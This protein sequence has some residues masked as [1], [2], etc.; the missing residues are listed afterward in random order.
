MTNTSLPS[1]HPVSQHRNRL[2]SKCRCG[3]LYLNADAHRDAF[4][5]S[6]EPVTAGVPGRRSGPVAA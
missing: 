6:P 5:H 2:V 4:G 1:P 3:G